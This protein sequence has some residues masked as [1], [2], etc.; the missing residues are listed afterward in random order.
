MV[1][2]TTCFSCHKTGPVRKDC[3]TRSKAPKSKFDKG[4]TEVENVGN[5]INK[6]WKKK[7][8]KSTSNGEGITSLNESSDHTSSN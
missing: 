3:P 8:T 2:Q 4:K 1:E 6:S 7:E 5:E